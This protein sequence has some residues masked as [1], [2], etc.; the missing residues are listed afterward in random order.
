MK[1]NI[2][3]I[4]LLLV[5]FYDGESSLEEENV[6]NEFFE[7]SE[8][9]KELLT[10]AA[11]FR[12]YKAE[13]AIVAPGDDFEKRLIN[14]INSYEASSKIVKS[15]N[16]MYYSSAAAVVLIAVTL[17]FT[18]FQQSKDLE[19]VYHNQSDPEQVYYET[20]KALQIIAESMDAATSNLDKLSMVEQGFNGLGTF[21]LINFDDNDFNNN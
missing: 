21:S 14:S 19:N 7:Q 2:D 8:V 17:F 15:R 5:K 3:E 12:F 20:A 6:I 18:V 9:P 11:Q 16:Y 4:K 10:E 13:S 1:H